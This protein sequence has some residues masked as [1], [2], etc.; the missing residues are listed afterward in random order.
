MIG[1]RHGVA[2]KLETGLA[3]AVFEKIVCAATLEEI[4]AR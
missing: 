1:L 3:R 2:A 4:G